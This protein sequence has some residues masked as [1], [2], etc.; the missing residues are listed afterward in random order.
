M[1]DAG[2]IVLEGGEAPGRR[3]RSEILFARGAEERAQVVEG[4]YPGLPVGRAPKRLLDGADVVLIVGP[5]FGE[6]SG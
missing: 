3:T 1:R 4:F 2:F 5:D 6:V